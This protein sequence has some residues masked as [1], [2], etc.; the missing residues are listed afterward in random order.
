MNA[1]PALRR[2]NWR[3]VLT[4]VVLACAWSWP[5][6]WWRDM[7]SDSWM[8]W[9]IPMPLKNTLLMWGPGIAALVCSRLF[10]ASHVRTTTLTGG[11]WQR[12]LAFYFLPL[13]ALAIAGIRMQEMGPGIVHAMVLALAVVGLINVLGEELGWRGF[14]QD[15][16][17]PLPRPAR[18]V[19]IGLI[20]AGWHFTN[21]FA[22]REGA[23]LWTYLAWYLPL[24]IALAAVIGEATDRSRA[25]LVA[26]TLH[27]WVDLLW[28]FPGTSTYVVFA[29][30][31]PYWGW[32]LWT[33]P[34]RRIQ[35]EKLVR[36][37]GA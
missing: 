20:W 14:L 5:L 19:L 34:N 6:F 23:A 3:A 15:A 27:A 25:V 35:G 7:H 10:R 36:A 21:L 8:A 13:T 24:T 11:V 37:A 18:Y 26:V 32:M 31:I 1:I 9:R 29:A 4:F 28:E 16:L 17:R 22:S 30:S 33:W 12:S 2:V